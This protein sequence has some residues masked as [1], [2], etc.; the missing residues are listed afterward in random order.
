MSFKKGV[1]HPVNPA[2]ARGAATKLSSSKDKIVYTNGIKT[3]VAT[4]CKTMQ[5]IAKRTCAQVL[6]VHNATAGAAA[7]IAQTGLED[8]AGIAKEQ[9]QFSSSREETCRDYAEESRH[10][11]C[12]TALTQGRAA[13]LHVRLEAALAAKQRRKGKR[14]GGSR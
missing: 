8:K 11:F 4:Q 5:E 13:Q 3:D 10:N 12:A 1:L 14:T 2:T 6:G 7:D 9:A